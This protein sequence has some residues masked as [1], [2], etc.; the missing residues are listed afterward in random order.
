MN[1]Q[2]I[3]LIQQKNWQSGSVL[4]RQL[5][6]QNYQEGVVAGIEDKAVV[7][8]GDTLEEPFNKLKTEITKIFET[9]AQRLFR[10]I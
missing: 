3:L 6:C 2:L 4:R 1:Y 5:Y 7:I 10:N 9:P 8:Q